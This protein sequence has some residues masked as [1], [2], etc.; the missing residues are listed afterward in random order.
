[1]NQPARVVRDPGDLGRRIVERRHELHLTIA[2]VAQRAGMPA[3]YVDYLEQTPT[4]LSSASLMRLSRALEM[5][6]SELLGGEQGR[7][8]GQEPAAADPLLTELDRG[9]CAELLRP[10]GVG[11]LVFRAAGR[12]VAQPVNFR[13]LEGDIVFRST[14]GGSVSEIAREDPV[15]FEVDR[16]DNAMS[17]GWSV[18]AEG[19][20][21][22]VRDPAELVQIEALG[23]QPWAGGTRHAYFRLGVSALSGR[24]IVAAR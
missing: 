6:R 2:D 15:S 23:I 8:P 12:P 14:E 19:T 21:S 16:L 24:K 5:P 13:V 22:R 4:D 20:V 18:L 9:R 3:D 10:G 17:E 7:A 1:M 11:R